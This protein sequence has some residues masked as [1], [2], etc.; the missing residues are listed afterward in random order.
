MLS[1]RPLNLTNVVIFEMSIRVNLKVLLINC[2]VMFSFYLLLNAR[3]SKVQ[4][5]NM[6]KTLDVV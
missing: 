3:I 6:L 1:D 5:T 4:D 2:L